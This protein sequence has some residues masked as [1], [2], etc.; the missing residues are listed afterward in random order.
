MKWHF[1]VTL[2]KGTHFA[3]ITP[4]YQLPAYNGKQVEKYVKFKGLKYVL[5]YIST[6]LEL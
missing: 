1:I 2:C 4:S 3:M 6:N 5:K